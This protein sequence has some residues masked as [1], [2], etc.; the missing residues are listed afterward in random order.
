MLAHQSKG[1]QRRFVFSM[2]F[3]ALILVAEVIGGLISGSLALLSD[4]AHVFMDLFAL[5]LSLIA[6]KLANLPPDDAHSYGWHRLE[7]FAA[8]VNGLSLLVIAIGIW[9]EAIKRWLQPVAIQSMEMLIIAV[10]GLVVNLAVAL[11]LG[12]HDHQH[13]HGGNEHDHHDY[14]E[15]DQVSVRKDLNL[16]S[17]FLHVLGDAISSVGVIL[18]AI[19]IKLTNITWIDPLMS[20]LIGIIILVSSFRVLR[21]A[22]RILV[23]GV[24]EGLSIAKINQ[25][26]CCIPDVVSVHDLHVWSICSGTVALSAHIVLKQSQE[27][28]APSTMKKI[29]EMLTKEFKID[30][31][32]I[33]F[34]DC[35]CMNGQGGCN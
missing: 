2:V 18:A 8:L 29:K 13:E 23:E 9:V 12:G 5:A 27:S 35:P 10:I 4:A 32:T 7:V 1:I 17:A 22:M 15:H 3:T 19:L 20:I 34:E 11:I 28:E 6:L 21:G 24:P 33:Q 30:H 14:E 26:L 16:N 25:S 31:T